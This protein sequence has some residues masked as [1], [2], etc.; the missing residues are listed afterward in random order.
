MK[1]QIILELSERQILLPVVKILFEMAR[2][3]NLSIQARLAADSGLNFLISDNTISA[4]YDCVYHS[5]NAL[6]ELGT[7]LK[8]C[9]VTLSKLGNRFEAS[10][11]SPRML[12]VYL[13]GKEP[14]HI[15]YLNIDRIE[16]IKFENFIF[17]IGG[18]NGCRVT[19]L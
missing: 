1:N 3:E 16:T 15:S 7:K 5:L 13:E 14:K 4:E 12:K 2:N 8:V 9:D 18:P 17:Q 19:A 10:D 6:C 11:G